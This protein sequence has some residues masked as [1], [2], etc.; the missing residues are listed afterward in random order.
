MKLIYC[1]I[2]KYKNIKKQEVVFSH[3]YSVKIDNN[4]LHVS[5]YS[6]A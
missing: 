2:N 4:G 3:E 5:V 6:A 1:Y